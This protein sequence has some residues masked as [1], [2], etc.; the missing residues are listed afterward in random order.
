MPIMMK[1]S[2]NWPSIHPA[3]AEAPT[4]SHQVLATKKYVLTRVISQIKAKSARPIPQ[5]P[6]SE[7]KFRRLPRR[8]PQS[9]KCGNV[10]GECTTTLRVNCKRLV[11]EI[12]TSKRFA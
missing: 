8:S 3:A 11:Q 5:Y 10:G 6:R 12:A 1:V 4:G 9:H 7:A 2:L